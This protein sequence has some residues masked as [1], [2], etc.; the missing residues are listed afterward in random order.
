M[1][2]GFLAGLA[3]LTKYNGILLLPLLALATVL[4]RREWGWSAAGLL[5]PIL[6]LLA[7]EH[8]T[9]QLYGKGLFALSREYAEAKR[10]VLTQGHGFH[11]AYQTITCLAFLGG[12]AAGA[13]FCAPLLSSRRMSLIGGGG[14][15][16]VVLGVCASRE[17]LGATPAVA[18]GHPRW[19]LLV[20]VAFW[21][22][23]GLSILALSAL[24]WW[25]KRD[26]VNTL[27]VAWIGAGVLYAIVANW[28]VSGRALL[29][30]VPAVSIVV[31][32]Q[33]ER[34]ELSSKPRWWLWAPLVVADLLTLSVTAADY[35]LANSARQAAGEI[36]AKWHAPESRPLW[37]QGHWGFQ[38]Y[39]QQSGC[40]AVDLGRPET[41][42]GDLI[43]TP[44]NNVVVALLPPDFVSE[45]TVIRLRSCSWLTTMHPDAGGAFYS[46]QL[47]PLPFFFGPVPSELY[48]IQRLAR[49]L[50]AITR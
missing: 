32:R 44:Y 42:A 15:A 2:A 46:N 16:L 4:R 28:M 34:P 23:G 38:Y 6:M 49:P 7:Y 30:I 29:W 12:G 3:L 50:P 21:A 40:R 8:E 31:A 41:R 13:A 36:T 5:I 18:D 14:A 17:T 11:Y 47:G 25:R 20:Q 27:L 1:A 35:R 26:R 19:L 10:T 33:L 48:Y 43:V 37:F 39:I 9:A 24:A 45:T 22:V